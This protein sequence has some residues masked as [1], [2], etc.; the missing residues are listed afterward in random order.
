MG[1]LGRLTG[2]DQQSDAHNVVI[3]SHF[4]DSATPAMKRQIALRII[5]IQQEIKGRYVGSVDQILSDL[6]SQ[7]RSVQMNFVALACNSLGI[8]PMIRGIQFNHVTNPYLAKGQDTLER[9]DFAVRYIN[10]RYSA[11][12]AWPGES[13]RE[14]FS[15]WISSVA[16]RTVTKCPS[17]DQA[18]RVESG[19]N[20]R[21]VCPA[22]GKVWVERT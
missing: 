20:L 22:C 16:D 9:I 13:Q 4:V 17:C 11:K 1:F 10:D 12:V 18:V 6:N 19:K 7:P 5:E 14:N 15:S 8:Q 2:W 3:A 21:I